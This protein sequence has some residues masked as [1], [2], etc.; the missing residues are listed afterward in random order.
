MVLA[1]FDS[2]FYKVDSNLPLTRGSQ[3]SIYR[4]SRSIRF[5]IHA[6]WSQM[7]RKAKNTP[8]LT[9]QISNSL[10]GM[11]FSAF[12]NRLD[13]CKIYCMTWIC[14]MH[15]HGACWVTKSAYISHFKTIR[16]CILCSARISQLRKWWDFSR[17]SQ[18]SLRSVVSSAAT[19]TKLQLCVSV[20]GKFCTP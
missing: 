12:N 7:N 8:F 19:L 14:K 5:I 16:C 17:S 6:Q 10:Q 11:H 15:V 2:S 1:V 18:Q 9:P 20:R 4:P 3:V 13:D